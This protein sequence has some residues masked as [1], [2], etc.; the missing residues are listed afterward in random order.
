MHLTH[1]L[2]G[3]HAVLYRLF[4][5][6]E[7]SV[8]SWEL[9]D[10]QA[11]GRL[12]EGALATHADLENRLLFAALEPMLGAQSGPL[13]VMRMEHD[14]IEGAIVRLRDAADTDEARALL[15][16][17]AGTA[18]AHF[19]K[20]ERVLFPLAERALGDAELT[21]LG[22]RWADERIPTGEGCH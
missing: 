16:D 21:A 2:F 8:A 5:H 15:R 7:S 14:R 9:A 18:R 4:D 22:A 19:A 11:W 13:A 12:L 17:I 6:L 3:E 10:C 1:A 20:E